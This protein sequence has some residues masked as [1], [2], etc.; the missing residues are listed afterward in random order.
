[1]TMDRFKIWR[2]GLIPMILVVAVAATSWAG[3]YSF[4]EQFDLKIPSGLASKGWMA[5]AQISVPACGFIED[6]D[7]SINLTH[8]N[9]FELQIFLES[10]A[11]TRIALNYYEDAEE[12]FSGQNYD[13]TVFDDE[14]EVGI[15]EAD[16][17]FSGRFR[18]I[19]GGYL[20]DFNGENAEGIW[21]IQVYDRL[22]M[23][24]GVFLNARL[25]M[26]VNPEPATVVLFG[27]LA[28]L[29]RTKWIIAG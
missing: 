27:M 24:E 21:R 23:D 13:W 8:T 6:I 12:P 15:E 14:A 11:E 17:P 4:Q 2:V 5:D 10:P 7:V 18:P 28:M 9:V 29:L 16:A 26:V 19:S 20:A 1:M 3:V 22:N 25:D